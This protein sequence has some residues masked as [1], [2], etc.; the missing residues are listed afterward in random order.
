MH[1]MKR[2]LLIAIL[3]CVGRVVTAHSP[4]DADTL[5]TRPKVALVLSGGGA[6]GA[7]HVGV[8]RLIE[9]MQIPIDCVVGTSMGAIVG[10]LYAIGYTANDMDSLFMTQ[11]WKMLLG[12]DLPR[13]EQPYAQRVARK[14]YQ[15][16]I[17]YKKNVLT[18]NSVHYRD[19][20]IK[21]RRT[22]LQTF[23]KVLARPGLID[24]KNL[25]KTF[26]Q[27]TASYG[28]S[29]SYNELPRPFACVA[30]DLVTGKE[31]VLREGRLAESIRA[32]MSIPGVFYPV[33]K[34]SL[35]LVDG[36]VVNNYP[37]NVARAMGADI[38]IG[39]EVNS[40]S[41][42][43][44]DLQS[45]SSIFERLIGTLGTELHERNVGDT[46][47]LISP[48]V[49]RFPVMGF[50]TINLKQMID[51]GYQTALQSKPQLESL[52]QSIKRADTAK[53]ASPPTPTPCQAPLSEENE[54]QSIPSFIPDNQ[55][56]LGLR[57]DT[58][59]G[60]SALLNV[61]F[62]PSKLTGIRFDL[63]SRL[64]TNPWVEICTSYTWPNH[65]RANAAIMYWGSDINRFYDNTNYTL[66]YNLYGADLFASD[67]LSLHYDLRVGVRHDR[68][69]VHNLVRSDYAADEYTDTES[70]ESYTTIY[71]LLQGDE[72]NLP[73]FPTQGY[74]YGVEASYNLKNRS[75]SGSHFGALQGH[76]SAAIPWSN[77]TALLPAL[78]VRHLMGKSIPLIYSNAMGGYLPHRYLRQ[79]MPFTGIVGSEF[80]ERHLTIMHF[81]LR[82]RLLPDIYASGIINYAYSSN[83]LLRSTE[84]R[85][86]WGVG[87]Q[88]AYDTTIG[89]LALCAHWS[90]LYH[91][92]GFYFTLGL[93][94]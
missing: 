48:P 30:A 84:Q 70:H 65:M 37:V 43:A 26:V 68:F 44:S 33:Y 54:K 50:D 81:E 19:A 94:F 24:G 75:N 16:N 8:I 87:I 32:S 22:S 82:Q 31:V 90:D 80:M 14:Q 92:F 9:E 69:S 36:G 55:V 41:I 93:E 45:F 28:D 72:Y 91:Q 62:S 42:S 74:A 58:E 38:I 1:I 86:T 18:E 52:H 67:L 13:Q 47:I 51:I 39:V 10:A 88:L 2:L 17:P 66:R 20:G 61:G 60:A 71:A 46:D 12:N 7:A 83:H 5:T 79:Q 53:K 34:D 49:K 76:L 40:A 6:R 78:Y 15:I 21:V 25:M 64:Y 73:Y 27:L 63:T 77:T 59:E 3:V 56:A 89:P 29:I 23:P 57:F 11:D 4:Q 85:D 35:V